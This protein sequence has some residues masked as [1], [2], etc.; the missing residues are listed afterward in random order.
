MISTAILPLMLA[1][2]P[3]AG[4]PEIPENLRKVKEAIWSK[5]PRANH[6]ASAKAERIMKANGCTPLTPTDTWEG[7]KVVVLMLV[8]GEGNV[9]QVTPIA[10]GCGAVEEYGAKHIAKNIKHFR[11]RPAGGKM[12]WYRAKIIYSW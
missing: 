11:S 9:K 5:A 3:V 2:S 6:M 8:D 4:A 10:N 1:T 7:I 12:S